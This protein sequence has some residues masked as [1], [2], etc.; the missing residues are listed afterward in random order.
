MNFPT[1][2]YV[3][4]GSQDSANYIVSQFRSKVL[5]I[6]IHLSSCATFDYEPSI[7]ESGEVPRSA[8]CPPKFDTRKELPD[9][10]PTEWSH[11]IGVSGGRFPALLLN[12]KIARTIARAIEKDKEMQ[13]LEKVTNQKASELYATFCALKEEFSRLEEEIQRQE[14]MLAASE[15][16]DED[17]YATDHLRNLKSKL[18]HLVEQSGQLETEEWDLRI[19]L[20]EQKEAQYLL[21][22]EVLIEMEDIFQSSGIL[23]TPG[24]H[25]F[26]DQVRLPVQHRDRQLDRMD[27]QSVFR[28]RFPQPNG[29]ETGVSEWR[30]IHPRPPRDSSIEEREEIVSDADD[31]KWRVCELNK[32]LAEED[33]EA[34]GSTAGFKRATYE[35]A[36]RNG[37]AVPAQ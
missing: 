20:S 4:I 25:W 24:M 5:R 17:I 3:R 33:F 23:A 7:T 29:G 12:K 32:T 9:R 26:A 10:Y 22:R 19:D 11:V 1:L 16:V 28:R 35:L 18:Q 36:R 14:N 2:Y 34:R 8:R 21:L 30:G 13:Q 37:E 27:L 6:A 31:D 15:G